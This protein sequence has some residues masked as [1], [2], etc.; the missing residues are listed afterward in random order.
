[1]LEHLSLE[2]PGQ[3]MPGQRLH[4]AQGAQAHAR[5]GRGDRGFEAD[6]VDRHLPQ[7]MLQGLIVRHHQTVI[8][9]GQHPRRHRV[10]R[11]HDA[12]P[13]SQFVE[14][15]AQK[16]FELRP[17]AEQTEAGFDLEHHGPGVMHADL[18][19]EAIGPGGEKLLPVFDVGGVVFS[20]GKA[21]AQGLCRTHGLTGTQAQ[22]PRRV[23]NRL[24]HPALGRAGQQRQGF[25]GIGA[26]T[27]YC[28]QRQLRENN[29]DPAHGNLNAP[30]RRQSAP[31][32]PGRR[33]T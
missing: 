18:G 22:R 6:P 3:A 5:Q 7:V 19:T 10:G 27:Q 23:V 9:V 28:V 32:G 2:T 12:V 21:F 17:G 31:N 30:R 33:G 29:A 20:R 8:G 26:L 16:R 24:Q 14:L 25:L 11:G 1:M 15:T 13:K 4:L